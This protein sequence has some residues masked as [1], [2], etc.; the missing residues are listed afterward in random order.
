MR[1]LGY[2]LSDAAPAGTL[3][4]VV[5]GAV[6]AATLVAALPAWLTARSRLADTLAYD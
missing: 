2:V 1:D 5:A 4:L 6:L 3:A